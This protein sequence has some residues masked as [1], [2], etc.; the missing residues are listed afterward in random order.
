MAD[1]STGSLNFVD[2]GNL[3][4]IEI[5]GSCTIRLAS[6][7]SITSVSLRSSYTISLFID[8]VDTGLSFTISTSGATKSR[9]EAAPYQMVDVTSLINI[10]TKTLTFTTPRPVTSS[11][12]FSFGLKIG[13]AEVSSS[14]NSVTL[15]PL[16]IKTNT[17]ISTFT[18]PL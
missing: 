16:T 17:R 1:Q 4:S 6:L 11:S 9:P 15:N 18:R 3:T 7:A 14:N 12:N 13:A 10:P 5:T 2:S 8:G